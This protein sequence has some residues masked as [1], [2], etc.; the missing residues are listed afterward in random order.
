MNAEL[1]PGIELLLQTLNF[2]ERIKGADLIITGEGR[3]DQ[4]SL[5]GKVPSGVLEEARKQSIPVIVVAG[6]VEDTEILNQAGFQGIYS[7]VSTPMSLEEA[8]KPETAKA[9]ISRTVAQL[10]SLADY[11]QNR[12]NGSL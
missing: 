7:I 1:K 8:I 5:M 3:V 10:I 12:K 4:Q 2:G 6:S 9:N 11:F